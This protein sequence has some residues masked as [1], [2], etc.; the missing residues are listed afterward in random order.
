V[1]YPPGPRRQLDPLVQIQIELTVNLIRHARINRGFTLRDAAR[2]TGISYST[3]A[4]IE[5]GR[6]IPALDTLLML[7][8]YYGLDYTFARA[9]EGGDDQ[10]VE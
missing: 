4:Y 5:Q 9:P 3:I 2:A 1:A 7:A 8:N 10:V 6:Q